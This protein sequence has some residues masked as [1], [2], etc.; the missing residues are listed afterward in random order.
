VPHSTLNI[1]QR[2]HL[3]HGRESDVRRLR[4]A[5]HPIVQCPTASSC[6]EARVS[7]QQLFDVARY[8]RCLRCNHS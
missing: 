3:E 1:D 4:S 8:N 5:G 7:S 6:A 2:V